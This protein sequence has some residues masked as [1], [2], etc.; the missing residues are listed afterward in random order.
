[1]LQVDDREKSNTISILNKLK[2]PFEITRLEVGDYLFPEKGII[3]E[4][5]SVE[6]FIGSVRSGRMQEQLINMQNNYEHSYLVIIGRFKDLFFRGI[7][8]ISVEQYIGMIASVLVRYN[9]KVGFVDNNTQF[10]KLINKINDKTDDGK[11]VSFIKKIDKK[12]DVERALLRVL[13]LNKQQIDIYLEKY[14]FRNI[15]SI[16]INDL[17]QLKG[18]GKETINKLEKNLSKL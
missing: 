9:V 7:K 2:I 11:S 17:L 6:D 8:N 13:G 10:C 12:E 3:V 18:F 16:N 1:M 4:R 5:K 15:F 14:I